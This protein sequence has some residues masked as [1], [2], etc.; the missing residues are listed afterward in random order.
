MEKEK[1]NKGVRGPSVLDRREGENKREGELR[2]KW[3][4]RKRN[5]TEQ[6]EKEEE[7]GKPSTRREGGS[8]KVL[9]EEGV[10]HW[11]SFSGD[12]LSE[13]EDDVIEENHILQRR[14][15]NEE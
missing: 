8:K 2:E 15:R 3:Q 10:F 5:R 7:E 11:R 6:K 13:D 12:T 4:K 1:T 9:D 14:K